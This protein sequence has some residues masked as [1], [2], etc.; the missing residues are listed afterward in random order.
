MGVEWLRRDS[1]H[2]LFVKPISKFMGNSEV[3]FFKKKK[4]TKETL[5]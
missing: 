2:G 5:P 4:K 1:P 3:A